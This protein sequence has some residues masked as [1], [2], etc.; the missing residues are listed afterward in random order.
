MR[1]V[2]DS[3]ATQQET[4]VYSPYGEL[5]Q[6]S[7][8]SQTTFG[9]T[10]ELTDG[11]GLVH[12]RARYYNPALGQF[13]SLDPLE[14]RNR[15]AY[16]NGNPINR[17]DPSGLIGEQAS[18][19]NS[20]KKCCGPDSTDW[21]LQELQIHA[22]W[23]DQHLAAPYQTAIQ[24]A[25]MQCPPI[26]G[27]ACI[28]LAIDIATADAA[29]QFRNYAK[30]IPHKWMNFANTGASCP[31]PDCYRSVTICN[32][33]IDRA[34]MGDM[35]FGVAGIRIG[36]T[37]LTIWTGGHQVAGGLRA[38]DSQSTAGIGIN[39]GPDILSISSASELCNRI[40]KSDG[41]WS[42]LPG[43]GAENAARWQWQYAADSHTQSCKPCS[44]Q[45]PISYSHTRPAFA[46]SATGTS[47]YADNPG[48]FDPFY[49]EQIPGIGYLDP[50]PCNGITDN[51]AKQTCIQI[52]GGITP[53]DCNK[54]EFP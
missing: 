21:F 19:C 22:R 49:R 51:F 46:G 40:E 20:D 34:K 53:L 5:T 39:I 14:T 28:L 4:R 27:G 33:C 6:T 38:A 1:T 16:V 26:L 43:S 47:L 12:L 44:E 23:V 45:L 13:V 37:P 11:N 2:L 25:A 54:V 42:G 24:T 48:Q 32:K 41:A 35:I 29:L 10:G 15:F 3:T 17:K 30:A 7:G 18:T 36:F 8:T 52:A 9:F 50:C 31:S